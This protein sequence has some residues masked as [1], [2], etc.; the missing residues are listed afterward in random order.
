MPDQSEQDDYRNGYTQQP[1]QDSSAHIFLPLNE[2]ECARSYPLSQCKRHAAAGNLAPQERYLLLGCFP[3]GVLGA[4]DDVLHLP[5]CFLRGPVGLGLGI[6]GQ[7]PT[8]SLT[9]PL[10]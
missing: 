6:A 10:T 4:A 2:R 7:L 8:V 3:N 9:A 1:K 5:C